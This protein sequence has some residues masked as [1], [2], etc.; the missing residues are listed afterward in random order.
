MAENT[1]GKQVAMLRDRFG[2]TQE[3]LA[4]KLGVSKQTISNWETGLKSPRMGAIEK[5]SQLFNVSKGF[6]IDGSDDTQDRLL[7]VFD[8]LNLENKN[9]VIDFSIDLLKNQQPKVVEYPNQNADHNEIHTFAAH[10]VDDT[11]TASDEDRKRIHSIL[12]ELDKKFDDKNKK[13]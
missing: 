7:P 2:F 1:L 4:N 5:M 11:Q 6:I 10:R 13:Q 8:Q 9:R 12:D 3:D